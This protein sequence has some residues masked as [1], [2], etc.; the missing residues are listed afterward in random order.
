[1]LVIVPCIHNFINNGSNCITMYQ[2]EGYNFTI[3]LTAVC[4]TSKLH[5]YTYPMETFFFSL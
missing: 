4:T 2:K 3:L 1:M 5:A